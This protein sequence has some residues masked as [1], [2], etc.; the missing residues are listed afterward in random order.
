MGLSF[1]MRVKF[2]AYVE[3]P[4]KQVK[5]YYKLA[6]LSVPSYVKEDTIRKKIGLKM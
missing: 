6:D 4:S 5:D 1:G 2:T 3:T